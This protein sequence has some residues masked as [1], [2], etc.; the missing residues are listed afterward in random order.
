MKKLLKLSL[1]FFIIT[2]GL[3]AQ[4][5]AQLALQA[6]D[7]KKA[8]PVDPTVRIGK[9]PN[10]ITYIIKKNSKPENRAELRLAVNVGATME[11]DDQQGLAHFTEHMAF[12]G[13][14]HFK[15]NELVC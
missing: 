14:T 8:I 6:Q 15:K 13:S 1:V 11:N 2:Q 7:L 12:N 3:Y 5:P 10:G 4:N 9:L